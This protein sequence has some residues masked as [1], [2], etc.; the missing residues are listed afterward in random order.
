PLVAGCAADA[1]ALV[2]PPATVPAAA[3]E[4]EAKAPPVEPVAAP[5]EV[6]EE[7]VNVHQLPITLD[8]VLRLAEDQNPQIALARARVEESCA[9]SDLAEKRWLPD[10]YIGAAYFRHE[11]GIQ[12]EDGTLTH[13]STGANLSGMEVHS[14]LDLKEFAYKQIMAQRR[15]HEQKG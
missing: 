7:A 8:T 11:G 15:L 6:K 1:V 3:A 4:E 5:Q 14:R 10:L 9:A 12:N 2:A 13:S